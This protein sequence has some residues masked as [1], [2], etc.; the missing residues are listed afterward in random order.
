MSFVHLRVHTEYSLADSIIRVEPPKRKGSGGSTNAQTLTERAVEAGL[1]A[2]AITDR[3]NLFAMVKFYK[4]AEA[5]GL[6]PIIG[7]DVRLEEADDAA[8]T[9]ATFLVQN[10]RGY[11]NLTRLI[12]RGYTEGQVRGEP[13]LKRDWI[14]QAAEGLIALIGADGDMG[15]CLLSGH[16]S[17]AHAAALFWMQHFPDRC[18]LEI[19]R[20]GRPDDDRHLRAAVT[21]ARRE[22]LPV[23]ATNDVRFLRRDDF[24]I[25]ETRV[26]IA[27]GRVLDDPRRPKLYT[28]E[29]YL[30]SPA[31]MRALFADLPEAIENSVE[32]ARRC[33]LTLSFGKNHLPRFPAPDGY[34]EPDYLRARAR[35]G[36]QHRLDVH[37]PAR[38][39]EEYWKRLD[40]E[41]KI[42]EQMGF[43][44]YFLVVSDFIEWAKTHGCP[45]GP[46]RGSGAGSLV[47]YA[48][49]ITDLDPL[50]YDLLF[51]RF[52]NPERVSMPDFDVDF[53][54]DNRDR[55]IEYVTQRYGRERVGQII[56]YATMAARG[57]VRDVARVMGHPYGFGDRLS[58]MI[59]GLPGATLADALDEVPDLKLAY[60][61]EEDVKAVIDMGLALEGVTRGVGKHAGGV[62][63]APEPLTDYAPLYCEAGGGGVVTQFDMKDLESVG[64]V[65]FDFLGLKTLTIVQAAVDQIKAVRGETIELLKLPMD[66][67]L[68]YRLFASGKTTAVFQMESGGMQGASTG[69]KPDC[70]EDIIALIS[71]Y[72]P[73]P[74]ELIPNY[75]DRKHGREPIDYLHPAMESVLKPTFGI[76]VYQEQVMQIAQ[77][78]AGYTLGG[79]DLLRRAM[80]K[81]KADE[82]AKQRAVFLE[83]AQKNGIPPETA[84]QVFDLMEKFANYGFNKSHAAAY[85]LVSYQTAWLKAHYPSEFMAAVLSCEIDHT[86][87]VVMMLDECRRMGLTVLPPDINRSRF[88][89]TVG[90]GGKILYGL[91]AIRGV[92]EAALE[93]ILAERDAS[94]PFRDLFDFC[95]RIDTRKANKRVLEALI[96]AGACDGF[97]LNRPS[98][99][100]TLPKALQ[101]AERAA[102]DASAGI[103]DLFGLGPTTTTEGDVTAVLE[104]DWNG[105]EKLAREKD[106]L[107]FYLSGHPIQSYRT[108][109]DAVGSGTFKSLISNQSMPSVL[110][111]SSGGDDEDGPPAPQRRRPR[112]VPVMVGAWLADV[113]NVGGDRPGKLLTLDD[114]TAQVI[115]WIDYDA[116]MRFQNVLKKDT[117]IFATGDLGLAQRE[118]RD[119]EWRLY[120]REFHD[121]DT[122]VKDRTERIVLD[123][124]TNGMSVDRLRACLEPIKT[125][126]GAKTIVQY[127]NGVAK[128]TLEL[129]PA[130]QIRPDWETLEKLRRL[131][132]QQRVRVDY[133]KWQAP[134]LRP[135]PAFS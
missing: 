68:T 92:G 119:P 49:G 76:F 62:V 19:M 83:G 31:E 33:T 125:S 39:A 42:I 48:I 65:K 52:L 10:E 130:W 108:V 21:F 34:T 59:P 20:C 91:G 90:E 38:P 7:A 132:G 101:L 126:Q 22:G 12:S 57:V 103:G 11:R 133:R 45:V 116:W 84:G 56:T 99:M 13:L 79:A 114:C 55:V 47:A 104:A 5:A 122:V 15:R 25:H 35:D 118:G 88:K 69:L 121:L 89:F 6:K 117:L 131:I 3:N 41:L 74:M 128:G 40:Y 86:E 50:P 127:A 26:C 18:Y 93:G 1:P 44:G 63:I 134:A 110:D 105:P 8:P 123:W 46:G 102:S 85:A 135:E 97:G 115:S 109:I 70:F 4:S 58:K 51:E 30:K 81:K 2:C 75:I 78:L 95:R 113:R 71:L 54:M 27:Q 61:K 64:L 107:G 111:S 80:G 36:L 60:E 106:T 124:P 9:R 43:A 82:M 112:R 37:Q 87:T 66:D 129:G 67:P 53:C 32:I 94:G 73:G 96:C 120:A 28:P 23:V 98:L 77:R 17:K 24:D 16:A 100:A 29:Q 14:A 72:R